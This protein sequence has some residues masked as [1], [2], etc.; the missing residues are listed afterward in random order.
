MTN[1][2]LVD[3]VEIL[4]GR[5]EPVN[6]V[7]EWTE[8]RDYVIAHYGTVYPRSDFDKAEFD[9]IDQTFCVSEDFTLYNHWCYKLG[10]STAIANEPLYRCH[11]LTKYLIEKG[12]NV[13]CENKDDFN[14]SDDDEFNG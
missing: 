1:D 6:V 8:K 10:N 5:K 2:E 4:L 11:F 13:Y 14:D 3:L 12:F 7:I 9:R